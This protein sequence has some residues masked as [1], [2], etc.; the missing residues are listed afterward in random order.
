[1]GENT[2]AKKSLL[3]ILMIYSVYYNKTF[4][5]CQGIYIV[6]IINVIAQL[7]VLSIPVTQFFG[8]IVQTGSN[9]NTCD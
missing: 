5:Y 7:F 9:S 6:R 4:G 3:H 8:S 1:M 2:E